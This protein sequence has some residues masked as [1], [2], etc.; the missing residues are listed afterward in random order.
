MLGRGRLIVELPGASLYAVHQPRYEQGSSTCM[1]AAAAS[2]AEQPALVTKA[3][4]LTKQGL[5][6]PGPRRISPFRYCAVR[7]R[8]PTF[9][10]TA[11]H[12]FRTWK[13]RWFVLDGPLLKYYKT[14]GK[15]GQPS[16]DELKGAITLTGC[17]V[18]EKDVDGAPSVFSFEVRTFDVRQGGLG[19]ARAL[20]RLAGA[21]LV[22][23]L[24]LPP[25]PCL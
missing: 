12:I 10:R 21:S 7:A 4:W 18:K 11:G 13:R 15:D 2:S 17:E 16:P 19:S 3:G 6:W 22:H 5:R 25:R 24:P 23:R 1:S 20:V 9:F 14:D 8:P